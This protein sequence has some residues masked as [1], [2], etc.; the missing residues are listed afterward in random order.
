M[1]GVR[2]STS[3]GVELAD[4]FD[5]SSGAKPGLVRGDR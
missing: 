4:G 3:C 1:N 2:A 5:A